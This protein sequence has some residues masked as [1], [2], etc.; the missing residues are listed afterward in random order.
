MSIRNMVARLKAVCPSADA[1]TVDR[2]A[3]PETRRAHPGPEKD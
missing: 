3:A 2:R 1:V